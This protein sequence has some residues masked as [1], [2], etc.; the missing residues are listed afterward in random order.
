MLRFGSVHFVVS[1]CWSCHVGEERE[2]VSATSRMVATI[3]W[4]ALVPG[5]KTDEGAASRPLRATR[6]AK[7]ESFECTQAHKVISSGETRVR[8]QSERER[9]AH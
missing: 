9:D 4:C 5:P 8:Q 1:L 6:K 7:G 2:K 3:L